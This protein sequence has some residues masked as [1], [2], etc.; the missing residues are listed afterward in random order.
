MN[1]LTLTRKAV[2]L[3]RATNNLIAR[4]LSAAEVKVIDLHVTLLRRTRKASSARV[5]EASVKL[6]KFTAD[7]K[8]RAREQEHAAT[9]AVAEMESLRRKQAAVNVALAF[10]ASKLGRTL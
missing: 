2:A 1:A 5:I 10:E 3:I 6:D 4:A 7:C 8:Q 9:V